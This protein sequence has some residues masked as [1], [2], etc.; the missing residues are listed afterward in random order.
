MNNI[1]SISE[2]SGMAMQVDF[3]VLGLIPFGIEK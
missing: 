3:A 1:L 2:E